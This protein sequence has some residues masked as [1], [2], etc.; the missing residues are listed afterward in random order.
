MMGSI[1]SGSNDDSDND[2]YDT[3]PETVD[4]ESETEYNDNPNAPEISG[5]ELENDLEIEELLNNPEN[6]TTMELN[7]LLNFP[8]L[9]DVTK[10]SQAS[11]A[12]DEEKVKERGN[13]PS[14]SCHRRSRS[15]SPSSYLG[16]GWIYTPLR[17]VKFP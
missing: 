4:T 13:H 2:S 12:T 15:H 9:L 17:E 10:I 14:H 6:D 8:D 3:P 11:S 5:D 1:L 16:S 7:K